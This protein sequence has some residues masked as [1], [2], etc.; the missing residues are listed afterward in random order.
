MSSRVWWLRTGTLFAT[1]GLLIWPVTGSGEAA[2]AKFVGSWSAPF[3]WPDVAI[4]LHVLPNGNVLS[5]SDDDHSDYHVNGSRLDGKTKAYVWTIGTSSTPIFVGINNESTNLFCSG[6]SFLSDGRLLIMGGHE[7]HDGDGS[8][9]TNIFDF[10][11]GTYGSWERT[12]SMASGRWYPT[13]CTLA[14]GEVVTVS[15][16][17]SG[18]PQVPE[19]F[20]L[21]ETW[22][23]LTTA[24]LSLPLYPFLHVAPDGRVF[25]SGP[26]RV[27]Q[28]LNTA[29]TGAWTDWTNPAVS[30]WRVDDFRDYGSAVQYDDGKIIVMGGGGNGGTGGT[31]P[32]KTAEVINLRAVPPA[33]RAIGSMAYGRRHLN[34]TLLADGK[35]LVTGGTSSGGFNTAAGAV[36]AA[37]IWDP[38]TE[39]WST[40]AS[41]RVKRL[42]HSSAVLLRDGRVLSAGGGRPAATDE[43][44]LAEHRDAEI[45]SPPYLFKGTRPT[46]TSAP[47]SVAYGAQFFVGTP[48]AASIAKVNWIRLSS[49][50]HAFNQ[51][52][53]INRL[54]FT[55][56]TGG[57]YVRAP[58]DR[59]LCPPGHY[60]LFILNGSGVPSVAKI[61]RIP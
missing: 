8:T 1:L 13:A 61:M 56:T 46:I 28:Y 43:N 40:V 30:P 48:N 58:S 6:H 36:Y 22:R 17:G 47:A 25:M 52:Q 42:Y 12:S 19:V 34:A 53:R 41:A 5:Y 7:G 26:N 44:P 2:P 23:E 11:V 10:R 31:L 32:K 20:Q 57:L 60:M 4:H 37:E 33:W 35:I 51:N 59:R 38:A 16:T 14:N 50:T 3:A 45:Y 21:N 54:T 39:R 9:D 55:E 27:T 15:G 18:T 29:G 49:A 24:S